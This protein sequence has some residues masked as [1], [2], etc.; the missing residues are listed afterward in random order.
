VSKADVLTVLG[1]LMLSSFPPFAARDEPKESLPKTVVEALRPLVSKLPKPTSFELKEVNAGKSELGLAFLGMPPEQRRKL[2]ASVQRVEG[3]AG[4]DVAATGEAIDMDVITFDDAEIAAQYPL[5]RAE[6]LRENVIFIEAAGVTL[7]GGVSIEKPKLPD[8]EKTAVLVR[9]GGTIDATGKPYT[10]VHIRIAEGK[11]VV[12]IALR[13][14][15]LAETDLLAL[16][17]E[18][19]RRVAELGDARP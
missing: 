13:N 3:F 16:L 15:K 5:W 7:K 1:I 12:E 18:T 11:R 19:A 6:S 4:A 8:S 17:A 9:M 14:L 10:N 2:D